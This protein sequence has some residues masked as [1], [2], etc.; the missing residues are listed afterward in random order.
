MAKDFDVYQFMNK[1]SNELSGG[2]KQRLNLFL[3]LVSNCKIILIDETF[4]EISSI[5]SENYPNGIRDNIIEQLN[6]W[7][8][9]LM[10]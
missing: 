9:I 8:K 3:S 10:I 6:K 5:P 2:E 7:N 1:S 4:S